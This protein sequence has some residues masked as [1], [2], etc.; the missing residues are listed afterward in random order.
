MKKRNMKAGMSLIVLVIT[1]LVMIILAGVVVVSLTKNNP[2][3]KAKEASVR[4]N[5]GEYVADLN[6]TKVNLLA[7]E[8][9]SDWDNSIIE[10]KDI[11]KY[12]PSMDAKS[13]KDFEITNGFISYIGDNKSTSSIIKDTQIVDQNPYNLVKTKTDSN[14]GEN[15][16]V[17]G[18]YIYKFI[19][20]IT[21][22]KEVEQYNMDFVKVKSI[23]LPAPIEKNISIVHI[24]N[25]AKDELEIVA[26]GDGAKTI[27]YNNI[28]KNTGKIIIN[29]PAESMQAITY[30]E[31]NKDQTYTC[32]YTSRAGKTNNSTFVK[33]NKN[34][35][36]VSEKT[37]IPTNKWSVS[38]SNTQKLKNGNFVNGG[39]VISNGTY[40]TYISIV[41]ES[42]NILMEDFGTGSG[43]ESVNLYNLNGKI[44]YIKN[45][46]RTSPKTYKIGCVSEENTIVNEKALDIS[47]V[48]PTGFNFTKL[49]ITKEG[50]LLLIA[51]PGVN[52][53]ESTYSIIAKYRLSDMKLRWSKKY[54]NA[55]LFSK[56]DKIASVVDINQID[57]NKLEFIYRSKIGGKYSYHKLNT[58]IK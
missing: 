42:G 40:K 33:L 44:Y 36:V 50:D 14:L 32:I 24:G 29:K 38:I 10:G 13:A 16:V 45:M 47:K 48:E 49:F 22:C 9:K 31:Q 4:H 19:L 30:F 35:D 2:I 41:D 5:M 53:N 27:I 25:N 26:K 6:L 15:T 12:I 37:L 18:E 58:V 8:N 34:L 39:Y 57:A 56:D 7:S 3:E 43:S 21:D 1:I 55:D 52:Y 51:A 20:G 46:N 11:Q 23:A 54:E 17:V 28:T